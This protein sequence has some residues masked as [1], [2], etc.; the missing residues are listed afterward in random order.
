MKN[1]M[2]CGSVLVMLSGCASMEYPAPKQSNI[3]NNHIMTTTSGQGQI[4]VLSRSNDHYLCSLPHPDAAFDQKSGDSL[5]FSLVS[6]K[7]EQASDSEDTEEVELAGRTPAV[8]LSR[9]LFFRACEFSSNYQLSKEEA[10]ALYMKTLDGVLSNWA[11]EAGRTNVTIGDNLTSESTI[12]NQDSTQTK[13]DADTGLFPSSD[14][15]S[16]SS[17]S[18]G[19]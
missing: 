7:E 6:I 18:D 11:I 5:E 4:Y 10:K 15:S 12:S 1:T 13:E 2:V 8:L 9:E 16:N 3:N 17:D 14:S 19:Y